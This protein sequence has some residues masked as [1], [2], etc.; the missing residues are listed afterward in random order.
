MLS[1]SFSGAA[2]HFISSYNFLYAGPLNISVNSSSSRSLIVSWDPLDDLDQQHGSILSYTI[3]C[4]AFTTASEEAVDVFF[5]DLLPYTM[6]NCCVSIA[7]TEFN[8]SAACQEGVTLEEGMTNT[9]ILIHNS[10]PSHRPCC[11][12][13]N[14][15]ICGW[16]KE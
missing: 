15:K 13:E 12:V 4:G 11:M 8:S 10:S 2:T 9:I 6:Y 7:T 14:L 1:N 3:S 5:D 16:C